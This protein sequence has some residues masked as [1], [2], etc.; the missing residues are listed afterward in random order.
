[1]VVR[2]VRIAYAYTPRPG[3]VP[4]YQADLEIDGTLHSVEVRAN[5]T[6]E[7]CQIVSRHLNVPFSI[8]ESSSNTDVS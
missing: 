7:T 2:Y 4:I 5:D 3:D 1:M 6:F 8:Y